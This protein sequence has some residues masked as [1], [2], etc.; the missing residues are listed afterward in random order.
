[1]KECYIYE[2][3]GACKSSWC[4]DSEQG[5]LLVPYSNIGIDPVVAAEAYDFGLLEPRVEVAWSPW[6]GG[7]QPVERGSC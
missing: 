6:W 3:G 5:Y 2:K 1:M 7:L 4:G